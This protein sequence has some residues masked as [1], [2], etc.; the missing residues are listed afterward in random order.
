MAKRLSSR[1]LYVCASPHYLATR[2][3]PHLLEELDQ[4]NCLQG[5]LEFWRFQQHG[6]ERNVKIKGSLRYNSGQALTDAALKGIGLVQ[7]PDYYVQPYLDSRELIAVLANYQPSDEGIWALFPNNRFVSPK[8]RM[9]IDH[10]A[11]R[12]AETP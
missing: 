10:L 2:G 8:V 1:R 5:T 12:L 6:M 11:A 9:L 4:H 7:L 3:E